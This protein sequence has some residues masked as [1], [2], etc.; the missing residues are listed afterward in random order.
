MLKFSAKHAGIAGVLF[1][2]FMAIFYLAPVFA[3][4]ILEPTFAS[5]A[6]YF[7]ITYGTATFSSYFSRLFYVADV[8]FRFELLAGLAVAFVF[9]VIIGQPQ[10]KAI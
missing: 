8:S 5:K 3:P 6:T 7:A 4:T 1:V 9:F 10:L 2:Y